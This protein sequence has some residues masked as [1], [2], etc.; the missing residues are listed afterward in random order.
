MGLG[1][2]LGEE[3]GTPANRSFSFLVESALSVVHVV[4]E[5]EHFSVFFSQNGQ[6][7]YF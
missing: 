2:T 1:Y 3:T 5:G 6:T 7:R 4:I